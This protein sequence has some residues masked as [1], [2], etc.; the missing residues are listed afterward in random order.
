MSLPGLSGTFCATLTIALGH[1]GCAAACHPGLT[2]LAF[3]FHLLQAPL[4]SPPSHKSLEPGWLTS[5]NSAGEIRGH[6]KKL[7][8]DPD[9]SQLLEPTSPT[10]QGT[11][12]S[13]AF[14]TDPNL[15]PSCKG[16]VTSPSG[17]P[18]WALCCPPGLPGPRHSL[19][20]S[21]SIS[22][23]RP[24]AESP[25]TQPLKGRPGD[26]LRPLL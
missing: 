8:L 26:W 21:S 14:L 18:Q 11:P 2:L 15:P 12:D 3:P 17:V 7:N 24:R 13:P 16:L 22:C 23:S 20:S 19:P 1:T 10:P 25:P 6:K 9:T 4:L 5:Q